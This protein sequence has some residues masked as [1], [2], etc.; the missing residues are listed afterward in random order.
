LG[1]KPTEKNLSA[2][3]AELPQEAMA[4]RRRNSPDEGSQQAADALD[5]VEVTDLDSAARKQLSVPRSVLGALVVNVD[6]DSSAAQAGLG[7]GDVITEIDRKPVRSADDAVALTQKVQ[8]N[9]LLLRVWSR[10]G[11]GPG[12]TRFLVVENSKNK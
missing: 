3:L 5:G 9:R 12:G 7:Q 2:T 10:S 11:P 4:S 1:A 6:P 8:G